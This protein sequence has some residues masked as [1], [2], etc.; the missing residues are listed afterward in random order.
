MIKRCLLL[1][2]LIFLTIANGQVF[3][4]SFMRCGR[5]LVEL[6]DYKYD[7]YDLCGEPA[8]IEFSTAI[9]GSRLFHPRHTLEL[10]QYEEIH[11]EEWIYNFG[12]TRFQQYLRFENGFLVDIQDLKKGH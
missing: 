11:I 1:G 12:S 7:V 8:S 9:V 4:K 3:A 10:N 2:A 5:N 6:G